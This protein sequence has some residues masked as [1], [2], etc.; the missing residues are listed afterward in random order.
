M[1]V[2]R[3]FPGVYT[4]EI[5]SRFRVIQ[6]VPTSVTAF[7]GRAVLGEVGA[8]TTIK[9]YRD[10]EF[11]FGGLDVGYPMSYAV[12]DFYMNGGAHAVIVR[13]Y[14]PETGTPAKA[15]LNA[16]G[17]ELEAASEGSWGNHL[18]V[19]VDS[20]VPAAVAASLG[21]AAGDLIN[22]TVR[23]TKRQIT[24]EF[25]NLSIKDNARRLDRVLGES[26][27]VRVPSTAALRFILPAPHD[28]PQPGEDIWANDKLSTPVTAAHYASDGAAL[29]DSTYLGNENTKTGIYALEKIEI[30]NILCIPPDTRGG[31]ISPGVLSRALDYCVTR[32]AMLI[33]DSP[34]SWQRSGHVPSA[35]DV[36]ALGLTGTAARNAAIYFP[37]VLEEGP[38]RNAQ[39]DT[40]APC[41]AIAG[42]WARTDMEGGVWKAPAGQA[43]S[44]SGVQGLAATLSDAE[45]AELNSLGIN[46]L[47]AFPAIG[48]VAWGAR[49]MRGDDISADEYKYI[50]VRRLALY[51]EQSLYSGTQW[52]VFEPNN[53]TLWAQIRLSVT[54]FMSNLFHQGAFAG[55]TQQQAFFVRCDS[56][57]TTQNDINLGVVN[58]EVGF[59]PLKPAEFVILRIQQIAAKP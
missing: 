36:A 34:F 26:G 59:A 18:R 53:E 52:A 31:D 48:T 25:P 5:P 13:L 2:Q 33:V 58:I 49:T 43:A 50:S 21:L 16:N 56:Q 55:S 41:G 45:N 8:P 29:K 35:A 24:E 37:R 27:L 30:F 22:L 17:L 9:T 47:R 7:I 19:R 54:N 51:I 39:V 4:E 44:L 38:L 46:S 3:N 6:D 42:V 57:T 32:R 28:D 15:R 1:P 10:F 20:K 11:N 12:R 23:D 14:E 40:F